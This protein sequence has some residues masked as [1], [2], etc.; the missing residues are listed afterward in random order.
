MRRL[1][2]SAGYRVLTAPGGAEG[3]E[4][5]EAQQVDLVLSDMRM[6]GMDGAEFLGRVYANQPDVLRVLLTGYADITSTVNAINLGHILRYVSKP[7]NDEELL[8]ILKENS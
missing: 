1:L 5:L 8:G 3:L 6:P 4:V 2:R 7:W